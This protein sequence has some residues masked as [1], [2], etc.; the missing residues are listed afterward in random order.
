MN[1][2]NLMA[3]GKGG[4]PA[5]YKTA[6][7]IQQAI[8]D[9]FQHPPTKKVV[10]GKGDNQQE[11]ELPVL[12]LTGLAYHLGF[13]SRQSF[14]DYENRPEFSYVLK[15]ARLFIEREYEMQ[16]QSGSPTGAIF[17]LKNFG[18]RDTQAIDHTTGGDKLTGFEVTVK[19]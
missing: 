3:M 13:E 12:T 2:V 6:D 16:L 8:D 11:I 19:K 7:D 9:Y 17:A 4:R 18:W 14:Y 15:R 10:I 5:K 1:V